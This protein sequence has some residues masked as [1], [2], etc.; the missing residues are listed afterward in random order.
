MLDGKFDYVVT[1]DSD[2]VLAKNA[3]I[4]LVEAFDDGR[5]GVV[6]GNVLLLNEKQ[7]LLTRMIAA[8]Y[9]SSLAIYKR[10]QS[11]FGFVTCCSGCIAAYRGKVIAS[12]IDEFVNQKFAG[13]PCTFS[14]D[15][16]LTN[17]VLRDGYKVRL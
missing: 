9:M 4:K 15:R 1:I 14:E 2:T 3:L 16:H 8:Y 11:T 13:E 7:N 10:S 6:T 17:L 12:I 5:V